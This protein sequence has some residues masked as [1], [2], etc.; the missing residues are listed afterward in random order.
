MEKVQTA[1]KKVAITYF[2]CVLRSN[3]PSIL[4]QRNGNDQV[5]LETFQTEKYDG[6]ISSA[7]KEDGHGIGRS[8]HHKFTPSSRFGW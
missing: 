3:Q 8:S 2:T 7:K 5:M 6:R 4:V 1:Y